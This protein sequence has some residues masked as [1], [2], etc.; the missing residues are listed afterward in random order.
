MS[1]NSWTGSSPDAEQAQ[2]NQHD[3]DRHPD[4]AFDRRFGEVHSLFLSC[5]Y[6]PFRWPCFL[7]KGGGHCIKL[8]LIDLVNAWLNKQ[9]TGHQGRLSVYARVRL[10]A[11]PGSAETILPARQERSCP[12]GSPR[13]A[14]HRRPAACP[15]RLLAEDGLG[16]GRSH[17]G[18]GSASFA[19]QSAL[20]WACTS[21]F[22]MGCTE[23]MAWK[24][25][26]ISP[27]GS[28]S[29]LPT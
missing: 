5:C 24:A 16:Q 28:A 15:S 14:G 29:S 23:T 11:Q 4:G 9:K 25:R 26:S 1:G 17:P 19:G 6:R 10:H 8:E 13:S 22:S 2:K 18:S 7:P 3:R 21:F 20:F 12:P 27:T